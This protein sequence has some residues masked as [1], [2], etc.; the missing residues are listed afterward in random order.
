MKFKI[1][2]RKT[3]L[4]IYEVSAESE[5]EAIDNFSNGKLVKQIN[6]KELAPEYSVEGE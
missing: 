2:E 5:Q 1:Y 6:T 4:N 3:Q